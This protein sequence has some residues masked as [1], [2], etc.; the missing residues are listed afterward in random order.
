MSR[1][2]IAVIASIGCA[3]LAPSQL[4]A[5]EVETIT[6]VISRVREGHGY[7]VPSDFLRSNDGSHTPSEKRELVDSLVYLARTTDPESPL[8]PRILDGVIFALSSAAHRSIGP[9]TPSRAAE[10]GLIGL[11]GDANERLE[12]LALWRLA[13]VD[14]PLERKLGALEAV[15]VSNRSNASA[16]VLAMA[17]TEAGAARLRTILGQGGVRNDRAMAILLRIARDRGW[18]SGGP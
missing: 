5:Q 2:A 15:A 3:A 9:G 8:G 7:V 18:G 1:V 13:S 12:R 17:R 10:D 11:V 16:A 4:R 14:I 6:D